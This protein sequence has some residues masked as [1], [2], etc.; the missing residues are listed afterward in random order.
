MYENRSVSYVYTIA[1]HNACFKSSSTHAV[2]NPNHLFL[3][4]NAAMLLSATKLF[5]SRR[6]GSVLTRMLLAIC[7]CSGNCSFG[8][9]GFANIT[10]VQI[11]DSRKIFNIDDASSLWHSDYIALKLF[12][13]NNLQR[14]NYLSYFNIF[15]DT[16]RPLIHQNSD[17]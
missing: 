4:E 17:K 2:E 11:L 10:S 7:G 16:A 6:L 9:N 1:S 15:V 13:M 5:F 3:S 12:G 14:W 8:T